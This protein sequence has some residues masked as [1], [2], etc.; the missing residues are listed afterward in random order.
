VTG[1]PWNPPTG[2]PNDVPVRPLDARRD[3]EDAIAAARLADRDLR[4]RALAAATDRARA[5]AELPGVAERADEARRLVA[6]ALTSER[7][8]R[9]AGRRDEAAR[10]DGAARVFALRLRDARAE[11]EALERRIAAATEEIE[12]V[13][14][15]CE[16]NAGRVQAVAAARLPMLRG[17]KAARTG[18]LVEDVLAELRR[19]IDDL[20]AQAEA[21]ARDAAA[22]DA[23]APVDPSELAVADEDLEREVDLDA[24]DAVL[25]DLRAELGID[26]PGPGDPGDGAQEGTAE[27]AAD[28]RPAAAE[29]EGGAA[30]EAGE[31]AEPSGDGDRPAGP[32][33]AGPRVVPAARA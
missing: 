7:D 13:R 8:A 23:E 20:V 18:Q 21:A 17:R 29:P 22:R 31:A 28:P 14:R 12:R 15:S 2:E 25:A 1:S 24:A 10:Y 6:R 26:A 16:E 9:R 27:D 30:A 4:A 32:S 33:P 19:P 3:I 5:A 11:H